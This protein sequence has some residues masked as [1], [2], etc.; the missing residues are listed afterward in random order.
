MNYRKIRRWHRFYKLRR[1]LERRFSGVLRAFRWLRS[2]F[3]WLAPVLAWIGHK[4]RWL[5]PRRYVKTIDWYLANRDWMERV[6]SGEYQKY[7]DTMYS[8]R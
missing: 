2:K 1:T 8:N 6:T 3:S 4:L 7:Y 5:N